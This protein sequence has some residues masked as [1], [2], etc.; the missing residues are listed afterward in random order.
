M[1]FLCINQFQQT[2]APSLDNSKAFP[3]I[4]IPR[5]GHLTL[6]PGQPIAFGTL[7]DLVLYLAQNANLMLF[8]QLFYI[9][10]IKY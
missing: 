1:K 10:L 5:V 9:L 6:I 2:P 7:V 8:S 3:C 4:S